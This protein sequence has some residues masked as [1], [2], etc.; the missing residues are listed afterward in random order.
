[1]TR[2]LE[3]KRDSRNLAHVFNCI[4]VGWISQ[5]GFELGSN[6]F[7]KGKNKHGVLLA[8]IRWPSSESADASEKK[9]SN[10]EG[11]QQQQLVRLC[12]SVCVC[13]EMQRKACREVPRIGQIIAILL[14]CGR[15]V[16]CRHPVN[17]TACKYQH[18]TLSPPNC[19]NPL[20]TFLCSPVY[21]SGSAPS[22][23]PSVL[24]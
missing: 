23:S 8:W 7:S 9:A 13:T 1:M 24:L 20:K 14:E 19:P 21:V 5:D 15:P 6:T 4:S 18:Q 10:P 22:Q 2:A 16:E 17:L 12:L 11:R 3:R